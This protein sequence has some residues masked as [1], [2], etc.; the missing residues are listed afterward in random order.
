MPSCKSNSRQ[1]SWPSAK[2]SSNGM[3][4]PRIP[5]LAQERRG[6]LTCPVLESELS[7]SGTVR[8]GWSAKISSRTSGNCCLEFQSC[9]FA[10]ATL[11]SPRPTA[12]AWQTTRR[13]GSKP[14]SKPL[15][16]RNIFTEKKFFVT[17]VTLARAF[18]R[19][20][21]RKLRTVC[22][23][24]PEPSTTVVCTVVRGPCFR[25]DRIEALP[26]RGRLMVR[27]N[28]LHL[29]LAASFLST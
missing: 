11:F 18:T 14:W 24:I 6:V 15:Q 7:L 20:D 9:F 16:K 28:S 10:P 12:I 21:R 29:K 4:A 2:P 1:A 23:R 25:D 17:P 8:C 27:E 13:F 5:F 26:S 3:A 22:F 19:A